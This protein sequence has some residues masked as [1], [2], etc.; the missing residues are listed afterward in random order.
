MV[1]RLGGGR[2][3][4]RS[5][6]EGGHRRYQEHRLAQRRV[7]SALRGRDR[8]NDRRGLAWPIRFV[9]G[10]L[11]RLAS[12]ECGRE[13][14]PQGSRHERLSC[15]RC[16]VRLQ[17][18]RRRDGKRL[19]R[20]P[21]RGRRRGPALPRS[22]FRGHRRKR[23]EPVDQHELGCPRREH[24]RQHRRHRDALSQG[25]HPVWQDGRRR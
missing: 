24:L 18:E 25:V 4:R 12:E 17:G 19:Y 11:C 10:G 7:A 21:L 3:W 8:Q 20:L 16:Q 5:R 22:R 2:G 14:E 9:D 6:D 23:S 13:G 15:A 1:R